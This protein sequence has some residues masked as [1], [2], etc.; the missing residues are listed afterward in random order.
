[1]PSG[2]NIGLD[3]NWLEINFIPNLNNWHEKLVAI[4][5]DLDNKNFPSQNTLLKLKIFK[6]LGWPK[7]S[8]DSSKQRQKHKIF[9]QK[10]KNLFITI[11]KKFKN[12]FEET[13]KYN[14]KLLYTLLEEIPKW[15]QQNMA[16]YERNNR[17]IKG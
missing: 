7:E 10:M 8:I 4:F 3:Y 2:F 14:A 5:S 11:S 6:I 17:K 16:N 15:F 13:K 1:M 9:K 12:V